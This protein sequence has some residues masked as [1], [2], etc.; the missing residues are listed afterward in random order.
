MAAMNARRLWAGSWPGI[1]T[2]WPSGETGE[3]PPPSRRS[4]PPA[5][6]ARRCSLSTGSLRFVVRFEIKL[7]KFNDELRGQP[8]LSLVMPTTKSTAQQQTFALCR[9]RGGNQRG[10][11]V[12]L[13]VC[14]SKEAQDYSRFEDYNLRAMIME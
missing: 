1:E 11:P 13:A 14:T 4:S 5:S 10:L 3:L 6:F 9:Y 12:C 8:L 2:D 7:L